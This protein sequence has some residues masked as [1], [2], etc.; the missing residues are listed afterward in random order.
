MPPGTVGPPFDQFL[1]TVT[2]RVPLAQTSFALRPRRIALNG[3]RDSTELPVP[4][5]I[6]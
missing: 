2:A 4:R 5:N 3:R 1:A 6:G